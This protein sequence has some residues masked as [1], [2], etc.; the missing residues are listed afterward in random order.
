MSTTDQTA[1]EPRF[2]SAAC[3]RGSH[4]ACR[5]RVLNPSATVA[6]ERW[7]PCSC[8][9]PHDR[10]DGALEY[11]RTHAPLLPPGQS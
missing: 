2:I 5:A 9:C 7:G 4:K 1:P 10:G 6:K 3:V 8:P 11:G